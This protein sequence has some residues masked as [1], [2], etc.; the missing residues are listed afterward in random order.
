MHWNTQ[1]D[2]QYLVGC[3]LRFLRHINTLPRTTKHGLSFPA[4]TTDSVVD[5]LGEVL[6]D[7][8]YLIVHCIAAIT[9]L[10]YTVTRKGMVPSVGL[11]SFLTCKGTI[12]VVTVKSEKSKHLKVSS[13]L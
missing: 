11:K 13:Q 7:C 8:H 1:V 12:V 3:H 5:R 10:D 4:H 9:K 2:V 6:I